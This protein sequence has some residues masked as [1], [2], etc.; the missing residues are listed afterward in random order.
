[1]SHLSSDLKKGLPMTALKRI[2]SASGRQGAVEPGLWRDRQM[3]HCEAYEPS[4]K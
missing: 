4:P 3:V 1:M 2:P